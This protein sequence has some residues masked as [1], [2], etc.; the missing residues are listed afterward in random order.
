MLLFLLHVYTL[1]FSFDV[2][3]L[4]GIPTHTFYIFGWCHRTTKQLI[5]HRESVSMVDKGLMP[6][7]KDYILL[8]TY[9]ARSLRE[10]D[11]MVDESLTKNYFHA[12]Y[13][14]GSIS[15]SMVRILG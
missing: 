6:M 15:E 11:S 10:S 2:E 4:S 3:G 7:T 8:A 5:L 13:S 14:A 9:F 12:M 1:A